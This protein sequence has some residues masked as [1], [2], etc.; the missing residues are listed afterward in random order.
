MIPTIDFSN[1]AVLGGFLSVVKFIWTQICNG[2]S[3]L[4]NAFVIAVSSSRIWATAFFLSIILAAVALLSSL[5]SRALGLL[6]SWVFDAIL[7]SSDWSF[8]FG[9]IGNFFP[10]TR[11]FTFCN[12]CI[13]FTFSVLAIEKSA[14]LIN[15]GISK[16]GAIFG[17]W[18]T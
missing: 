8:E 16:F 9:V 10:F 7:D 14:G 18:K 2:S 6:G 3:W 11:F 1:L 17:A 13:S 15:K 5:M 12:F 4:K